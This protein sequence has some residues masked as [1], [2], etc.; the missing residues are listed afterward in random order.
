MKKPPEHV[1]AVIR[2]IAS[3]YSVKAS[4]MYTGSRQRKVVAALREAYVKLREIAEP[5]QIAAWMNRDISTVYL[6]LKNQM[7][8]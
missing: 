1:L 6:G 3:K 8:I 2:A 7:L 5:E 4:L